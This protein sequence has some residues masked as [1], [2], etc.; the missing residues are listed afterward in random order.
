MIWDK[1]KGCKTEKGERMKV[2]IL[3]ILLLFLVISCS[4]SDYKVLTY[5]DD[6]NDFTNC[7]FF[8]RCVK[9]SINEDLIIYLDGASY[10]STL[11]VKGSIFPWKSFSFA[12]QLQK[13]LP[14]NFDL[15]VPEKMGIKAG[16]DFS[17]DSLKLNCTTLKNRV[18][19]A[20]ISIDDF[21]NNN[22]YKNI[23]LIGYSEGG[24]ILPRVY[25]NLKSKNK[26]SKLVNLSGG[27]YSYYRL[28]KH[29]YNEKGWDTLRVDSAYKE[30]LNNPNS[31]SKYYMGHP[32]KQWIDFMKYN[33][34]IEYKDINIPILILHGVID[35]NATVESARYL[36]REIDNWGKANVT[37]LELENMN[38][39]Y[40]NDFTVVINIITDWLSN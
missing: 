34:S 11:G 29:Y 25:N 39:N 26:I 30:I 16:E 38:H 35:E 21:L 12:Y 8:Q 17:E 1:V 20:V 5:N 19:S 14:N 3:I 36:K 15:L 23:Y 37:Y 4:Y 24:M 6:L 13:K 27:G 32:Y 10:N 28:I 40:N 18:K 7:Y 9:D 2:K 22:I 33:P 31:L